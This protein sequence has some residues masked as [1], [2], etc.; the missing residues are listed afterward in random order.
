MVFS[1]K[2]H[3]KGVSTISQ[4]LIDEILE[5]VGLEKILPGEEKQEE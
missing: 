2:D 3:W 1:Y 4:N 5:E